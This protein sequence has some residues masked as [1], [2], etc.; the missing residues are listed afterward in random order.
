MVALVK[1]HSRT[2]A[3]FNVLSAA[4]FCLTWY[5]L[6]HGGGEVYES[7]PVADAWLATYGWIGLLIFK[8]CMVLFIGTLAVIISYYRPRTSDRLLTFACLVTGFVVVYS[9]FLAHQVEGRG[10]WHQPRETVR[11]KPQS[12]SIDPQARRQKRYHAFLRV[13]STDLVAGRTSL[14]EAINRLARYQGI[15]PAI[16]TISPARQFAERQELAGELIAN[17]MGRVDFSAQRASTRLQ[18]E[19]QTLFGQPLDASLKTPSASS[20][21]G[22]RPKRQGGEQVALPLRQILA[23]AQLAMGGSA[24]TAVNRSGSPNR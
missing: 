15:G 20:K 12:L 18:E 1:R 17:V 4:D 22:S 13:L 2:L 3:L 10:D 19:Y 5:L 7:N 16:Y 11:F 8:L 6:R 23:M 24:N 9:L 14:S 21:L